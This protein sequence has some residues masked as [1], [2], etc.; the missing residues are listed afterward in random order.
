[1]SSTTWNRRCLDVAVLWSLDLHS[2][3]QFSDFLTGEERVI[4]SELVPEQGALQIFRIYLK[5]HRNTTGWHLNEKLSLQV[6]AISIGL[7]W[8]FL[9]DA[10][11]AR[12]VFPAIP[13]RGLPENESMSSSC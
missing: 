5:R 9:K 3:R 1:M 13:M 2:S 10:L 8:P 7:L 6:N 11:D 12:A 4:H